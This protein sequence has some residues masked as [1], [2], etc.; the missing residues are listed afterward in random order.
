MDKKRECI[1]CAGR[2]SNTIIKQAHS[3]PFES[4]VYSSP[5]VIL[6]LLLFD[7]GQI[8][9]GIYD[10]GCGSAASSS[11]ASAGQ[12]TSLSGV[13]FILL[14][15][16]AQAQGS[17]NSAS[18]T[19]ATC[20]PHPMSVPPGTHPYYGYHPHSLYGYFWTSYHGYTPSQTPPQRQLQSLANASLELI[21][22]YPLHLSL[23]REFESPKAGL[24]LTPLLPRTH[25]HRRTRYGSGFCPRWDHRFHYAGGTVQSSTF[26]TTLRETRL[27]MSQSGGRLRSGVYSAGWGA[28]GLQFWWMHCLLCILSTDERKN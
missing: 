16:C 11:S 21:H 20:G 2:I 14:R 3:G 19:V 7:F 28:E 27:W 10:Q 22:F 15:R 18:Y 6:L 17:S 12:L 25:H 23:F 9:A 5:S 8:D 1:H 24:P 13:L 4:Q 26:G